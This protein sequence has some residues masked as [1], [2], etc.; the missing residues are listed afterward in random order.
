MKT[1]FCLWAVLCLHIAHAQTYTKPLAAGDLLPSNLVLT[2][3]LNH[4][5]SEIRLSD[6]KD[7]LVIL[8]FW[9]SWCTNCIQ[10]FPLLDS[11]KK[12]FSGNL[13]VILINNADPVAK[14]VAFLEKRKQVYSFPFIGQDTLLSAIFPYSSLP[15]YVWLRDGKVIAI[16]DSE[17][18]T[19]KNISSVILE[20]DI[21]IKQKH[22]KNT[23]YS[24]PLGEFD[25]ARPLFASLIT[26]YRE[27]MDG[28]SGEET[29]PD[30]SVRIWASNNYI[31]TLYGLVYPQL[32]YMP[33]SQLILNVQNPQQYSGRGMDTDKVR[34]EYTWCYE[35]ILPPHLRHLRN[36]LIKD[37]LDIFFQ[38][39]T[40]LEKRSMTCLVLKSGPGSH[41][42]KSKGGI[43][44]NTVFE[45]GI[46]K[47]LLNQPVSMLLEELNKVLP[48]P[49]TDQTGIDYPIDINLPEDLTNIAALRSH[50]AAVGLVLE[51]T[52]CEREVFILTP[53]H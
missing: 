17:A 36:R 13:E 31:L 9:S 46:K 52:V 3:V 4:P 16:T 28:M 50:F 32:M 39:A 53:L 19:A 51:E 26:R 7:K 49:L 30:S 23:D 10:K 8:D 2:N 21:A 14:Q 45:K 25:K 43:P 18:L 35:R 1:L 42:A 12:S 27:D 38:V 37:D 41:K 48:M 40:T 34:Y 47:Q 44:E 6:L 5:V 20:R 29:L 11:L 15:H 33:A 24:Q 22:Y